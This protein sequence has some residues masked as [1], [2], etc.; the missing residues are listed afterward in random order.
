[1]DDKCIRITHVIRC[2][3]WLP[4]LALHKMLYRAFG[5]EA[6]EF[7]HLPLIMKPVGQGKLSKRDGDKM[8]FP[9]FPLEWHAP[10]GEIASGYRE[11][12]YLPEAVINMLALLG[13][14][15]GT[16]QEIFSLEELVDTFDITRV[17]KSGAKINT[18]KTDWFQQQYMQTKEDDF[19]VSAL[20]NILKKKNI[21]T[22][23]ELNKVVSLLKERI[24]FTKDLWE[25]GDFFF[26]CP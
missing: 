24:T 7:A 12:G 16:E 6:P 8:G 21:D 15:P 5:W 1:A 23:I 10:D 2:E 9:V 25:Q 13:W 20:E 22:T 19:L 17:H 3:E 26:E 18:E 4:S 11:A 14:N